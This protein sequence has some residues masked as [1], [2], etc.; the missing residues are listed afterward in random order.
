M[1]P[2]G[3]TLS[4]SASAHICKTRRVYPCSGP[5]VVVWKLGFHMFGAAIGN[6]CKDCETELDSWRSNSSPSPSRT[7]GDEC[8]MVTD[9]FHSD[10]TVQASKPTN[11]D[12]VI[13]HINCSQ[14][15]N[16]I[17]RWP[18]DCVASLEE[19]K[20]GDTGASCCQRSFLVFAAVLE[21]EPGS[22]CPLAPHTHCASFVG[23]MAWWNQV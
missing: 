21:L 17:S 5:Y 10:R 22:G 6:Q 1:K 20:W 16:I 8:V 2:L 4:T 23:L 18:S 3:T 9:G 12:C 14:E 7:S 11:E 15:A 19:M 13:V